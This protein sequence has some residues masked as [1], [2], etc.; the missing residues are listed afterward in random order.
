MYH[1]ERYGTIFSITA[2]YVVHNLVEH[3]GVDLLIITLDQFDAKGER[4]LNLKHGC[5]SHDRSCKEG[6]MTCTL[7]PHG[8]QE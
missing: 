7:V 1:M 8:G 2:F 4:P 3:P 6:S 5:G